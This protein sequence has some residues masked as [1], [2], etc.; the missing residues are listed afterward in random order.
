MV[1]VRLM[2]RVRVS[3]DVRAGGEVFEADVHDR[4]AA[5]TDTDGDLTCV[6]V[7]WGRE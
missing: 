7:V 1:M 3:V 5:E 6:V 4:L 2:F